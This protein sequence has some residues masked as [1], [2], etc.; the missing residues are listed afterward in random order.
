MIRLAVFDMAGTTLQDDASGVAR[1]LAEAV[2]AGGFPAPFERVNQVM[3]I[4]KIDAVRWIANGA[5][6]PQ[7]EAMHEDFRARM[8]EHYKTA[9][10][11]EP[12]EGIEELFDALQA[13]GV[14]IGLD[15]GFDAA[16]VEVILDRMGW[17]NRVDAWS[18]SDQVPEGRPAPHMIHRIMEACGV[19]SAAE[20]AKVGDT[21]SDMQEGT[22]TGC[23]WVV[24]V[25]YGTHTRA[26]LQAEPHTHLVDSVAELRELLLRG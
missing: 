3:G 5:T 15:T 1:V 24:G 22:N 25:C 8:I 2:E 26:Q 23:G 19:E 21:P 9:P 18:S 12:Y 4:K 7:V 6:E 10:A 14:K 11:I 13:A 20:V 16:T 17:Q